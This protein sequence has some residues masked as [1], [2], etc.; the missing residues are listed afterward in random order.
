[1]VTDG[2]PPPGRPPSWADPAGNTP[3]EYERLRQTSGPIVGR[4][5]STWPVGVIEPLETLSSTWLR[6]E[7]ISFNFFKSQPQ[8]VHHRDL[9]K[10]KTSLDPWPHLCCS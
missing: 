9:V 1:M 2:L 6:I 8:E 5:M 10:Q 7:E 3:L 4:P